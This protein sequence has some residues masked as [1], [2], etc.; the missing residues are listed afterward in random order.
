MY[1]FDAHL[2]RQLNAYHD[3]QDLNEA[4]AEHIQDTYTE[5]E[6][7]SG[8]KVYYCDDEDIY[9]YDPEEFDVD[10]DGN[11]EYTKKELED[12]EEFVELINKMRGM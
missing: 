2:E 11:F 9:F 6:T 1:D 7:I 3:Q 10:E 8:G 12:A 4:F 5:I